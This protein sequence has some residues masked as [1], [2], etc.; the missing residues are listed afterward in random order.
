MFEKP[1]YHKPT[2]YLY[3]LRNHM[4]A[5][6]AKTLLQFSCNT[7]D[8]SFMD[9]LDCQPMFSSRQRSSLFDRFQRPLAFLIALI[10]LGFLPFVGALDIQHT[11]SALDRDGHEHHAF[12]ICQ[13]VQYHAHSTFNIEPPTLDIARLTCS[14]V[15]VSAPFQVKTHFI[16]LVTSPRPPPIR[17]FPYHSSLS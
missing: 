12:D 1:C 6:H 8:S 10:L 17:S 4:M 15:M 16:A 5:Y 14:P 11:F 3:D 2:Q 7:I 13:W 9:L